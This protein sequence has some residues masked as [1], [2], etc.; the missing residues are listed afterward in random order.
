MEEKTLQSYFIM[1]NSII[2]RGHERYSQLVSLARSSPG[3]LFIL[4]NFLLVFS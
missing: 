1:S 2:I 4:G 3:N